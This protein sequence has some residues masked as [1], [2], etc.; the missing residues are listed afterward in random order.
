MAYAVVFAATA[1]RDLTAL[2]E[3]VAAAAVEFIYGSLLDNPYRVGKALRFEFVGFH[4]A[5]R[6]DYRVVYRI[7]DD[8]DQILVVAVDHRRRVYRRSPVPPAVRPSR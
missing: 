3:K 1:R 6:G 5:R 4:S 8:A 7:D 2:P